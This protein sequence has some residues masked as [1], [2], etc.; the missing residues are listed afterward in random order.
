ML[1]LDKQKKIRKLF[2]KKKIRKFFASTGE[3]VKDRFLG[4][5]SAQIIISLLAVRG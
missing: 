5:L 3:I 2:E 1:N 4:L